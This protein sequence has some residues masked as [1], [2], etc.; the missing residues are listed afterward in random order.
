[1]TLFAQVKG[2]RESGRSGADDGNFSSAIGFNKAFLFPQAF[3]TVCGIALQSANRNGL[4]DLA[5][6]AHFFTGMNAYPP[7]NSRKWYFFADDGVGFIPSALRTHT[8]VTGNVD[9]RRTG[10]LAWD[11]VCFPAN[12]FD[13]FVFQC[14]GGAYRHA[15]GAKF[16]T[17][18]FK[19]F[20][21]TADL[22]LSALIINE[23]QRLYAPQIAAGTHAAG[24]ANAQVIVSFKQG[25]IFDGGK[26]SGNPFGCCVKDTDIKGNIL[27]FTMPE[28]RTA[29]FIFRHIG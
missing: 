16:T 26:M 22:H 5:A 10:C 14:T 2:C 11:Q 21:D 9:M 25:M 27:Q 20:S 4:V 1:M 6:T 3:F 24:A 28:L 12:R 7:Q 13:R 29:A 23:A 19:G 8:Q 17:R 18:I 15:S